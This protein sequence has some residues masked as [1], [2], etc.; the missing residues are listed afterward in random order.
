MRA[1]FEKRIREATGAGAGTGLEVRSLALRRLLDRLRLPFRS[2]PSPHLPVVEIASPLDRL[3]NR[4]LVNLHIVVV[5]GSN[6]LISQPINYSQSETCNK[7]H[8]RETQL[9]CKFMANRILKSRRDPLAAKKLTWTTQYIRAHEDIHKG[10]R[11]YQVSPV[12]YNGTIVVATVTAL[13]KRLM[14]AG[15][16]F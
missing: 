5:G 6:L 12:L 2:Y 9:I 8:P 10:A 14:W 3:C 11:P 7:S 1:R 16:Q 15:H 4:K 13:S